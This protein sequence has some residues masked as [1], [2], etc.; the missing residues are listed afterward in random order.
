MVFVST[1]P[2]LAQRSDIR[3]YSSGDGLSQSQVLALMQDQDGYLWLGNYGGLSRYD[4]RR[5]AHIGKEQGLRANTVLALAQHPEGGVVVGTAGGGVCR[6]SRALGSLAMAGVRCAEDP[7]LLGRDVL[8][9][10]VDSGGTAWAATTSGLFEISLES[11]RVLRGF[12]T[13][14]GLRSSRCQAV[15]RIGGRLF[16]GTDAGLVELRGERFEA[17]AVPELADSPIGALVVSGR[18]LYAGTSTALHLLAVDGEAERIPLPRGLAGEEMN[19]LATDRTG[20]V[21][22]A[23]SGGA[24]RW[25]GTD[26]EILS[27]EKGLLGDLVRA[28]TVDHESNVWLGT[29]FGATKVSPGPFT[30]YGVE[31][32]LP[33]IFVR[34]LATDRHGYLWAGTRQGVARFDG[35]RFRPV[36]L[37]D[38]PPP[39]VFALA[40]GRDGRLWIGTRRR[41]AMIYFR[42]RVERVLS[43]EDGLPSNY[44]SSLLADPAG[45]M[46]I[47]TGR[48]LARWDPGPEGGRIRTFPE[49]TGIAGR[50]VLSLAHGEEG[51]LWIGTRAGGL[52]VL[53]YRR[54]SGS[55]EVEG[56]EPQGLTAV[57][58]W[59]IARH[60]DGSIWAGSNGDGL[61]RIGGPEGTRRITTHEG[62]VNDFV[63]Q[64]IC[65]RSGWVWA[66]TNQGLTR[67]DGRSFRNFDESDGLP[68][69]EGSATAAIEDSRGD[70][71]F[72]TGLGIARYDPSRVFRNLERP[73]VVLQEVVNGR[74][75]EMLA[76]ADLGPG[77]GAITFHFAVLSYR[78][79]SKTRF[80]Y[81]L[82]G[83]SEVWSEPTPEAT[84][85]YANLAPASYLFEVE[86]AN[87]AGIWSPAPATFAFEVH[88]AFWQTGLFRGL[89]AVVLVS[90]VWGA[91]LLRTRK[92][93]LERRR[94]EELVA[95]R[96]GELEQKNTS[97]EREIEERAQAE[98]GR[99]QLEERLRQSEK[100]EAVG[101]LAGGVAHDFNNLLTTISGYGDLLRDQLGDDHELAPEVKEILGASERAARLTQQLLAFGR[102]QVVTPTILGLNEVVL[103]TSRMLERLIGEDVELF[104]QLQAEP[105]TVHADR[106]Q[107]EQVLVNLAINARDAMPGGGQLGVRT[108]LE[109]LR[110]PRRGHGNQVIDAGLY[111]RLAVA[112]TGQGMSDEVL[113]RIFEPFFTT[114]EAGRGT[115]LGL[116]TVYG[117]VRQGEGFLNVETEVGRGTTFEVYLPLADGE[118]VEPRKSGQ[119]P[120]LREGV[121]ATVLVLEDEST[122]RR[123]V[124]GVLHRFGFEVREA[125]TGP[126]A[127]RLSREH[128]GEIHLLLT[129]VVMP[130]G[131]GP[132]VAEKIVARRP[133]VRVLYISG[134]PDEFLGKRGILSEDINFLSKPFTPSQ[135][136]AKVREVLGE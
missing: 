126:G 115:G 102:K 18:G 22:V 120:G 103:D 122:L 134:Y 110:Q 101:R 11:G 13:S 59:S 77:A 4:G 37:G 83:A 15:A 100:M 46:W 127:L 2:I 55:L 32:G 52:G 133:D 94:L 29:D 86:G 24:A 53:R 43:L 9:L 10:W 36:D 75:G 49:L 65:D 16:A 108:S 92:L 48:G 98:E 28:V 99:K 17:V 82:L 14:D 135:L 71:W 70:L 129:D 89:A 121:S 35:L 12:G 106:G 67:W 68:A 136:L 30:S 85:T 1:G 132:E 57:T 97:L 93:E 34:A 79:E 21:W 116:A 19:D 105:D 60:S 78:E 39:R 80:R 112:D 119:H 54:V 63:W 125:E 117:I 107:L 114:K 109:I 3:H 123:L 66:F 27:R 111:V 51:E 90:L 95:E 124:C 69:R 104:T 72:G 8:D 33:N 6:V 38:L 56:Y 42:D 61:F 130:G 20:A 31:E 87:D 58:V 41:G 23:T 40:E 84:I 45:G 64:V 88:P 47:A 5:F 113:E 91:A 50:T 76:G 74:G 25:S 96:T 62:L 73:R 81:R 7:Q 131:D 128:E 44:V 118:P 26:F